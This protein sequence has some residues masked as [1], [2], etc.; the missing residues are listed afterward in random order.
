[1]RIGLGFRIGFSGKNLGLAGGVLAQRFEF[2]VRDELGVHAGCTS[3]FFV[4]SPV[5]IN[6]AS[7]GKNLASPGSHLASPGLSLLREVPCA[8]QSRL[9]WKPSHSPGIP[10]ASPGLFL[11]REVP[12][13]EQSRLAW[14]P[15]RSPG[16]FSP[17]RSHLAFALGLLL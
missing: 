10:L 12:C 6:L 1:M 17:S 16:I 13:A 15:S 7:P 8:E 5:R 4:K 14:K 11:L 9:A 3:F 2:G